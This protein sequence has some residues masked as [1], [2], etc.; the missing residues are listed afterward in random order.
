MPSGDLQ[1]GM[2][3][4]ERRILMYIMLSLMPGMGPVTESLFLEAGGD[5]EMLFSSGEEELKRR[6]CSRVFHRGLPVI[7]Q[8]R[9]S[10][11]LR[12][13][14]ESTLERCRE[15]GITAI[16]KEMS[17]FPSRFSALKG[18]PALLYTI[19]DLRING[20]VESVGIVGARRCIQEGKNKSIEVTL[21][22]VSAGKAVI[23]G[24]AKG[25]DSYA[26]TAAIRSGGY[27]IAVLG[28]GP[29]I[30]YPQE[31]QALYSAITQKGCIV[32]EYPP[33][34]RPA[35]Y[36]FPKRN[37]LIAALC[38]ELYIIGAGRNSGTESTAA[39]AGQ[40][41]RKIIVVPER[42]DSTVAF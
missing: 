16:T 30:C 39:Y 27:T 34:T 14:A 2:D 25:I 36:R 32:S 18:M 24:M 20:Y 9:N 29:D 4:D 35:A 37:R 1:G 31:H 17:S 10:T 7:L 28:S 38:D 42:M 13:A 41:G 23:S 5:I 12:D 11:E 22:A 26:H 19:G 33:G 40:Y 3:M 6:F 15:A 8:H 21:E